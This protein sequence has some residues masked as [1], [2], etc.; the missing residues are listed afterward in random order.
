MS[1]KKTYHKEE[2]IERNMREDDLE[3]LIKDRE[4][5]IEKKLEKLSL[6]E[7]FLNYL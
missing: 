6:R 4:F 5:K 3:L 1:S 7:R 2:K